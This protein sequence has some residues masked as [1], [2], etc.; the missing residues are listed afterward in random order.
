[1][2]VSICSFSLGS[3]QNESTALIMA[4]QNGHCEI[5]RMLLEAKA[6]INWRANVSE[7]EPFLCTE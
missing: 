7:S 5:V 3:V 6:D 1:M 4:S 2:C